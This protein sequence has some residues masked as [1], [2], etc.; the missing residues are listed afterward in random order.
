MLSQPQRTHFIGLFVHVHLQVGAARLG[1]GRAPIATSAAQAVQQLQHAAGLHAGP[2]QG[3]T[4][5]A[6]LTSVGE[7]LRAKS[8][9]YHWGVWGAGGRSRDHKRSAYCLTCAGEW[10]QCPHRRVVVDEP[11][12]DAV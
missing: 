5:I 8:E 12:T 9:L 4:T 6:P 7:P 3:A 1:A 10:P 11:R 2:P